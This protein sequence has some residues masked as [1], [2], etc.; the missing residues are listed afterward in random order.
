MKAQQRVLFIGSVW[1]EPNSSAAGSRTMQLIEVFLSQQ[2]EITFA[3]TAGDSEFMIDFSKWNLTK[4][5]IQLNDS[6]FDTF[7]AKLQPTVVI[8]DRFM[9]EEQFGWRV[10]EHCPNALRI[11]DTID[12]HCLRSARQKAFKENRKFEEDD[13]L[14][15]GIT[16]R[17]IASILRSDLS[18]IISTTELDLLLHFFKIEPGL[19]YYLP[20]LLEP[21]TDNDKQKWLHF[22]EREHF[23]TIGNFL[24]EPNWNAVLYLKQE[25]WPLLKK[26]LP[27]AALHV[28]GAYCPQKAVELNNVKDGFIV[29][30]R[31]EDAHAVVLAARV[32]LAPLRFG[33]GIKGKLIDAM[34]CGTPS[35]T[36]SI[37]AEGMHANLNWNGF[38]E[39]DSS[40][41]VKSAIKLYTDEKVWQRCQ[42]YGRI[43][44]EEIYS[45]KTLGPK[46]ISQLLLL[47]SN[48]DQA[49]LKNFMGAMLLHHTAASTKYLSK[50]IEAKNKLN[51]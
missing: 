41:F 44:V 36:T 5:S 43:I 34:Q 24:H 48:L 8:F 16:K 51:S 30:G 4:V 15:E 9:T 14:K 1:P 11:L 25:L 20:F 10:A 3:S 39:D 28:Y 21:L 7:V 50:W 40:S 47:Q 45:R 6:R 2:W 42:D 23:V 12:L 31:A 49:R 38:I 33:A 46:F 29:K 13:L 19:L 17:E 27:N 35:V 37:G 26:E 32:V 18:L 22:H